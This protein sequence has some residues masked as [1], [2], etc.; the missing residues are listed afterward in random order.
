MKKEYVK[1]QIMFENFTLSSNIAGD[2]EHLTNLPSNN[3]CGLY[4][5]GIG[6]VF[7]TGM[8][9]CSD[10]QVGDGISGDGYIGSGNDAICYHVPFGENLFNS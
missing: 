3:T 6:N 4:F 8:G 1:P 2:C 10:M 5:T 7:L 9:G